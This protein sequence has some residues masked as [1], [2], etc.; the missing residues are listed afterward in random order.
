MS[1]KH[2]GASNKKSMQA[3]A[4]DKSQ[5]QEGCVPGLRHSLPSNKRWF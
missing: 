5:Q 4:K 2:T 1:P 3:G